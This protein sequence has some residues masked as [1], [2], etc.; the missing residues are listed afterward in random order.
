MCEKKILFSTLLIMALGLYV[1]IINPNLGCEK[2]NLWT[3]VV[4][5]VIV[6]KSKKKILAAV[7]CHSLYERYIHECRNLHYMLDSLESHIPPV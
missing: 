2:Q 4:L 6:W 5:N 3:L 7:M 1:V